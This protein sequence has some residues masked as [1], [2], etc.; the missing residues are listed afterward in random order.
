MSSRR[1]RKGPGR[2]PQS[3]KRQRFLWLIARGWS[4]YGARRE[5]GVSRTTGANWSRGYK[6]YKDG[7]VVGRV[8]ALDPLMLAPLSVRFLSQDERLEIADLRRAG[9]PIRRIAATVGRS[10]STVSRELRRNARA[11][12]QYRPFE[13]HRTAALARRRSRPTK[14]AEPT[15]ACGRLRA[16]DVAMEPAADQPRPAPALPR[17][18]RN[19]ALRR[20]DLPGDLPPRQR[21][22]SSSGRAGPGP[23]AVC[24]PAA[25]TGAH[26][27]PG[28]G[29]G[30]G[31]PIR[32]RAFTTARSPPRIGPLL[33]TGKAT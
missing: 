10:P 23:L 27:C 24:A 21:T 18:A 7:E 4:V 31:S 1:V 20:V 11:D 15:A 33:G 28:A 32:P 5:V 6:V 14:V 2:R 9:H 26:R 13:A 29:N 19:A 8:P 22:G 12:G 16:V 25:I 30:L 17:P 3:A